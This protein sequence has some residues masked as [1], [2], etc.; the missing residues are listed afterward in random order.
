MYFY[1]ASSILPSPFH[2]HASNY[3]SVLKIHHCP[4]SRNLPSA[5]LSHGLIQICN[6]PYMYSGLVGLSVSNLHCKPPQGRDRLTGRLQVQLENRTG[7]ALLASRDGVLP[8]HVLLGQLILQAVQVSAH[9]CSPKCLPPHCS[10]PTCR[11]AGAAGVTHTPFPTLVQHNYTGR[12]IFCPYS[13][14]QIINENK[15]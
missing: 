9:P 12:G 11:C 2:A 15:S 4:G 8:R 7:S 6:F 3:H 10:C 14:F 5:H 1:T 13:L